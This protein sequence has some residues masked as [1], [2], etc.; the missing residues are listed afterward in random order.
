[1]NSTTALRAPG[2]SKRSCAV[3]LKELLMALVKRFLLDEDE[4]ARPRVQGPDVQ[5]V[6]TEYYLRDPLPD[7]SAEDYIQ[8]LI[9]EDEEENARRRREEEEEEEDRRRRRAVEEERRREEEESDEAVLQRFAE[10]LAAEEYGR[11]RH[12]YY[13]RPEYNDQ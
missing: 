10:A 8:R 3:M 1:M 4:E 2:A 5:T 6:V 13:D 9:E 7:E 12:E 11:R